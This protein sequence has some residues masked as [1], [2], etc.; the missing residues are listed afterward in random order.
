[1]LPLGLFRRRNFSFAN[2]ETLTVYAGLSTL[3]V[4]P[5][6]V[7]AAARRLL[8][9]SQSGLATAADHGRDVRPLAAASGGSRCGSARGSFM[10]FGPARLRRPR[11]VW[12]ARARARLRLLDASC[13]P[14][15]ARLRGRALD[16][17]RAAH[18]DRA[19]RRRRRATPASPRGVNNAVARVAGL[20]GIAVVGA[21]V[22]GPGEHARPCTASGSRWR[23]PPGCSRPAASIGLAGIRNRPTVEAARHDDATPPR[24][25]STT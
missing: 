6:A 18:R 24:S 5:R 19:R 20:L 14:P 9:A 4:L 7:P 12:L 3:H 13:C 8:A 16:D 23:S 17:R 25:S 11:C 1:M 21:A 15:L 2:L 10:G 22:G